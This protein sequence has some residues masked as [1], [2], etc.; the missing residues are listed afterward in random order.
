MESKNKTQSGGIGF[1]SALTI[2]FIVLKLIGKIEWS[3]WLV[4]APIW[5][6]TAIVVAI[7]II[8]AIFGD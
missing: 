3:W 6:P 5:I 1:F 4:L 8:I 2:A 7:A